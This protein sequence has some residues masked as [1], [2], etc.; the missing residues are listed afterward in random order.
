MFDSSV[1]MAEGA[2]QG[3]GVDLVPVCKCQRD[4]AAERLV[5]PLAIDVSAG[6]YWLTWLRSRPL[7][8]GMSAFRDW[9]LLK[10]GCDR[11]S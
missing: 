5:R 8:P 2:V 7:T 10:L 11:G 3:P 1:T 9:L 6:S 4:L